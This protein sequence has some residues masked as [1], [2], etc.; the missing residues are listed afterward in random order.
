MNLPLVRLA[1]IGIIGCTAALSSFPLSFLLR[2]IW[3][4]P[5]TC[6]RSILATLIVAIAASACVYLGFQTRLADGGI[7]ASCSLAAASAPVPV[8]VHTVPQM[9]V[10]YASTAPV[11]FSDSI[12]LPP[13][14]TCFFSTLLVLDL[15]ACAGI[16]L[17]SSLVGEMV[18]LFL[19]YIA[20]CCCCPRL[21]CCV[22]DQ[23][24]VN[25]EV[26]SR[27]PAGYNAYYQVL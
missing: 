9:L 2:T 20:Y 15:A 10:E 3:S 16:G 11:L 1:Q 6:S 13:V 17:V 19:V 5:S 23:E 8:P 7:D 24:I 12:L 4:L 25:D 27:S 22:V 21:A 26:P 14:P 18:I